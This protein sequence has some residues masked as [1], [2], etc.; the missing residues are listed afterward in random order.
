MLLKWYSH[1]KQN[2]T[3]SDKVLRTVN[4]PNPNVFFKKPRNTLETN[5]GQKATCFKNTWDRIIKYLLL[6]EVD[7]KLTYPTRQGFQ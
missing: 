5:E 7:P 3:K 6:K 4:V 1:K 2:K